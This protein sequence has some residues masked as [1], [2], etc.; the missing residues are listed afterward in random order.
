MWTADVVPTSAVLDKMVGFAAGARPVAGYTG[1][2]IRNVVNIG[3]GGSDLGPV[4]P[5]MVAVSPSPPLTFRFV[6]NVDGTDSPR[7]PVT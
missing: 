4:I 7:P 6:S 2:L 1:L 3:I 5:T